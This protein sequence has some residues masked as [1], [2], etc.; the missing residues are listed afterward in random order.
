MKRYITFSIVLVT[1]ILII[2]LLHF[3]YSSNGTEPQ[4]IRKD[5]KLE[6]QFSALPAENKYFEHT[7]KSGDTL[8]SIAKCYNIS[9]K[10]LKEENNLEKNSAL[11][12]GQKI[13]IPEIKPET[14]EQS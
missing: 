1:E 9:V 2:F 12:I 4:N 14:S 8:W 11:K 6:K 10:I 5:V 7:V 13:Q 3:F